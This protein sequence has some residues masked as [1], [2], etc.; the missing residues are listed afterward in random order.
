M[1]TAS[2][3]W[4]EGRPCPPPQAVHV[5][6]VIDPF[7]KRKVIGMVRHAGHP[8]VAPAPALGASPDEQW[9]HWQAMGASYL[10]AIAQAIGV[11]PD[12]DN[13]MPQPIWDALAPSQRTS[14]TRSI[15][16]ADP[17][18][19]LGWLKVSWDGPQTEAALPNGVH[20]YGSFWVDRQP[21]DGTPQ[22]SL[23]L[24]AGCQQ[25]GL[26]HGSDM[27]L[28]ITM[29]L[30][31]DAVRIYGLT[32]SG[33]N[34]EHALHT[35]PHDVCKSQTDLGDL[36]GLLKPTISEA[37]RHRGMGSVSQVWITNLERV[38]GSPAETAGLQA[39]GFAL[40]WPEKASESA[41]LE[42]AAP[43][44]D[45]P[46]ARV[47]DFDVVV[48]ITGSKT[49][50]VVKI[51]RNEYA[52]SEMA[53][54]RAVAPPWTPARV[55]LSDAASQGP[56]D[57]LALRRP[58]RDDVAMRDYRSDVL[59]ALQPN[60]T[61]AFKD[62]ARVIFETK[63]APLDAI[64]NGETMDA[65][66]EHVVQ[67][68]AAL[69]S[70]TADQYWSDEHASLEAH[71]RAAEL[72]AR[73]DSYGIDPDAYFRF[74]RLPLVQRARAAMRWAPDGE[75]PNA[76]VR[77]FHDDPDIKDLQQGHVTSARLQLMV[78]YGSADPMIRRQ[79]PLPPMPDDKHKRA[80]GEPRT[81]A[82][83]LGIA[84]DPRWA[85]H[86][87]GHVLNYASTGELEF[88]FA[89]SAGDALGAI[90]A[91]PLSQLA[92]AKD[93]EAEIR[94]A[95]YPWIEVPGRSHG[96]PALEGYCWCGRRNLLRLDFNAPLQRHHHGYYEEQ[97]LSSS[98]FRLYRSLG[99][100]TRGGR[101]VSADEAV[102]LSASD[103]CIFLIMRAISMLGPD[104]IVP[105]RTV[106]QFVSALIDADLGTS[107]WRVRAPWPFDR[108]P[109][110]MARQ[111]GRVHKV[112]RWAFERQGLYATDD[113]EATADRHGQPP[114]VDVYIA[115]RRPVAKL[116]AD[117][118]GYAP[119]P[120]RW[121]GRAL[122]L[123]APGAVLLKGNRLTVRVGNRG[124]ATAVGVSL[125]VWMGWDGKTGLIDWKDAT[126][127]LTTNS[128]IA[129]NSNA[130]VMSVPL[131]DKQTQRP[132]W[133]LVSADAPAD[134]SNLPLGASPPSGKEELL[135]LIA[136]DNNLALARL[137]R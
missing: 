15:P 95:S 11:R 133:A 123:A 79:V 33:L 99:G 120:L 85:W 53:T 109:R 98:L 100:D 35:L 128:S 108:D 8:F 132:Q 4:T 36:L 80:D 70:A 65:T 135:E 9:T 64:G 58:S 77:P 75:L 104:I 119:V 107:T 72:F 43:E 96:R 45:P 129:A 74:A 82:Q 81:R 125:R 30:S 5:E 124:A 32:L 113:P 38:R 21:A 69:R 86:E 44:S 10:Q 55:F 34:D 90:A 131:N 127:A 110:D 102:R 83:Y 87:F 14:G 41:S 121:V 6:H 66:G 117:P 88:P 39:N 93:P 47:Y 137:L 54:P 84:S 46:R 29:H 22:R 112:I 97:M 114:A 7:T 40:R 76:E 42:K 63:S 61:L 68:K 106:D 13:W 78:K 28:R 25:F 49:P 136:S 3:D 62:Q 101:D 50:R 115:D 94:F 103:Y 118:G 18:H 57:T 24:L 12:D 31:G 91:D 19:G 92:T 2:A 67:A 73:F 111:G 56:V 16:A 71:M 23:V 51:N 59:L 89:H 1:N 20:A 17:A 26:M 37:L 116:H 52:G 60:D 48:D 27:G 122:W 126:P 130:V 105:A 134:P